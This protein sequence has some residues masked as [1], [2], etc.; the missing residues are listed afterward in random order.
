[1]KRVLLAVVAAAT[2][3]LAISVTAAA[4]PRFEVNDAFTLTDTDP[5]TGLEHDV[6]FELT[7]LVHDHGGV[8]SARGVRTLSTT[9]GYTGGGTSSYVFNGQVEMFRANDLLVDGAGNRIMARGLFVFDLSS[10]D[11]RIDE[12][13]LTCVGG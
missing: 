12:F 10:G 6:S 13:T 4:H 9:A 5:C 7:F 11:V 8:V 1:M 3:A 2:I